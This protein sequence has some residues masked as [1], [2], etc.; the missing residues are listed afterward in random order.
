[1]T[2][3]FVVWLVVCGISGVSSAEPGQ[4]AAASEIK[5]DVLIYGRFPQSRRDG[6]ASPRTL[7]DLRPRPSYLVSTLL[8]SLRDA[9]PRAK[10]RGWPHRYAPHA[11][12]ATELHSPRVRGRPHIAR[13][14][15]LPCLPRVT[16]PPS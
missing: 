10:C 2:F 7:A 6:R 9:Q 13:P 8:P 12:D 3:V 15:R 11:L 14:V 16:A 1:M 5:G 4:P